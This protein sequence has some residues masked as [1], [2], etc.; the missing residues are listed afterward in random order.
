MAVSS[1][2]GEALRH[3]FEKYPHTKHPHKVVDALLRK[4]PEWGHTVSRP[5]LLN[6][7]RVI[8]CNLNKKIK[9]VGVAPVCL[10]VNGT[11]V[12]DNHRLV[13]DDIVPMW[14]RDAIIQ[15]ARDRDLDWSFA[16]RGKVKEGQCVS[17]LAGTPHVIVFYPTTGRILVYAG[18]RDLRPEESFE[19]ANFIRDRLIACVYRL[20]TVSSEEKRACF[21]DLIGFM[22]RL[23]K[24]PSSIHVP[25]PYPGA[26]NLKP[27]KISVPENGVTLKIN[28]GTDKG[29]IEVEIRKS[30]AEKRLNSLESS[31][32]DIGQLRAD[33]SDLKVVIPDLTSTLKMFV[34]K[35]KEMGGEDQAEPQ[36]A[37][38]AADGRR[39]S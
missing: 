16:A 33:V 21:V 36:R 30:E 22:S 18:K 27:G 39:Y 8:K 29:T 15:A 28:D 9:H 5:A 20:E 1:T 37:T 31:L 3:Y 11:F 38:D 23:L 24:N 2:A 26:E 25:Y 34:A 13:W 19:F 17:R 4:N 14:L 10:P 35:L 6:E 7:A 32:K 12:R